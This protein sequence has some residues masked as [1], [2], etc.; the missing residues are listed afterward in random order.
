MKQ[1]QLRDKITDAVDEI[2]SA[3]GDI[4]EDLKGVEDIANWDA[5]AL[6]KANIES[7]QGAVIEAIKSLTELMTGLY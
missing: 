2:E 7:L 4:L 5:E 6:S 3:A 1:G